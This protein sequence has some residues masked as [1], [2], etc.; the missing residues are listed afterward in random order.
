MT[1]TCVPSLRVVDI[2]RLVS[3]AGLWFV[4]GLSPGPNAAFCMATGLSYRLREAMAAPIGMRA[5]WSEDSAS[6]EGELVSFSDVA[7]N[8]KPLNRDIPIVIGGH[9]RRAA[10]RAAELGNGFYP[11]PGSIDGVQAALDDLAAEC[12]AIGRERS[13]IEVSLGFPGRF[14]K[15]PDEAVDLLGGMGVDRIIIPSTR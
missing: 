1:E 4:L 8:P 9:S 13:E 7:M 11:G 12:E 5:L 10:R 2:T 6:Y 3:F 14:M 15:T